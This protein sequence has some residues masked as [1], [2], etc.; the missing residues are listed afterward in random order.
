[1]RLALL[2]AG[3]FTLLV[4][5]GD[6]HAHL[7]LMSPTP[8]FVYSDTGIKTEPCGSGTKTNMVASAK[9]GD[10]LMVAWKETIS[11]GGHF[12]IALSANE[13]DFVSPTSLTVP[14]N[15]PDW[16][17][18][19]GITDKTGTMTYTQMVTLPGTECPKCVLQVIQ[20][21]GG[22]DGTNNGTF[23]G[24]YFECADIAIVADGGGSGSGGSGAGGSSGGSGGRGGGS[25]GRGGGSDAGATG[26]GGSGDDA[27]APDGGASGSG[28]DN[29]SGGS[30]NSG[31]GGDSGSGGSSSSSS[32]GSS[33]TSSG[34]SSG[35]GS[36]GSSSVTGS[37]GSTSGTGS[38]G[39]TSSGTGGTTTTGSGGSAPTGA[40]DNAP[41][42]L[43]TTAT[44]GGQSAPWL[45]ALLLGLAALYRRRR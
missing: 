40:N 17:L 35:S 6:A 30:G 20:V 2:S 24:N 42:C 31:S 13:S 22:T 25:G 5:A 45:A 8:R 29:G 3:V 10:T 9:P 19:D 18:V 26:S 4:G 28:G 14:A 1:M 21:M 33:G 41:G 36:G 16:V 12:R 32:G 43:C 15:K 39:T 7:Q 44:G 37:G 11:H 34:G 38:G 23:T 27:G